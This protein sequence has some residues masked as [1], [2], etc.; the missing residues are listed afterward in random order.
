MEKVLTQPMK[1]V[2]GDIQASFKTIDL[3]LTEAPTKEQLETQKSDPYVYIQ[4]RAKHLLAI[5]EKEGT[6]SNTYPYPV[7]TWTIGDDFN[8]IAL[9]G[10][11]VVD[12]SLLFKHLYGRENTWVTGYA[13]DVFAYIPSLRVL[14]EGGYEANESMI[15]YGIYGP[16][17]PEIEKDIVDTVKSMIANH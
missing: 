5:W 7:Q 11:V 16:W 1:K 6:L 8:W 12:Y 2:K 9:A 10:E 14:R 13:N 4:R 3:P 15:Y 17:K